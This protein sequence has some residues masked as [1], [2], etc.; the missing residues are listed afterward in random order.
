MSERL[1]NNCCWSSSREQTFNE[2][3]KKCWYTYYGAWEG[4]PLNYR[5]ARTEVDPLASYLYRLKNMQPLIFFIG[6]AVHKI[7][8]ET[9]KDIQATHHLPSLDSCLK[10]GESL[11]KKGLLESKEGAWKKHPKKYVNLLEDYYQ[12]EKM[13]EDSIREKVLLCIRNW[14]NSDIAQ[15]LLLHPKTTIGDVEKPMPFIVD[16]LLEGI[17]V[18]DLYLYWKKGTS[19]EKLIIFDWKTGSEHNRIGKQLFA[20]ALA[21]MTLLDAKPESIILSPFYVAEG[22][23]SYKKISTSLDEIEQTKKEIILALQEMKKLHSEPHF[24]DP[25]L[26]PYAKERKNCDT[27]PFQEVCHRANYQEKSRPELIELCTTD[28]SA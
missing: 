16:Q 21:A 28:K 10:K 9:I 4:W 3:R 1:K 2:C 6:S 22:P 5:D 24:P 18:Y 23:T 27:C 14:Y 25:I 17:V 15:Q 11:I 7:I 13:T 20:Y 19:D 12:K 8:E 26:F